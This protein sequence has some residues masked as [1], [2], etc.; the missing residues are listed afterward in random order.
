MCHTDYQYEV[1]TGRLIGDL[2]CCEID[3]TQ[4]NHK[5]QYTDE[6]LEAIREFTIK[7]L[8]KV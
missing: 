6:V 5:V 3:A 8:R 4:F 7:Y 1:G 2:L